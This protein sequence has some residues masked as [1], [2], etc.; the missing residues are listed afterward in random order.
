MALLYANEN[1]PLKVVKMLSAHQD[2]SGLLI[3]VNRPP[4]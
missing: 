3:R 1:F 4:R 2:L